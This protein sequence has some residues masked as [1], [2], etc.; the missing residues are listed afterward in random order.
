MNPDTPNQNQDEQA[1]Q[2]VSPSTPDQ[3]PAP[4]RGGKGYGKKPMWFWVLLYLVVGG[5][6]YFLVY[7]FFIADR[8]GGSLY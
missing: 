2:P 3:K 1:Q 7:Y 8:S 6:I 5:L 4:D